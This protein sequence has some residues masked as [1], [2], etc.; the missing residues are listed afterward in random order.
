MREKNPHQVQYSTDSGKQSNHA[1]L[2]L[3]HDGGG[4]I[5]SYFLLG[6]L[7]RDVWAIHNPKYFTAEPWEGGIDEMASHYIELMKDAGIKGKILLGGTTVRWSL[8]GLLSLAIAHKLAAAAAKDPSSCD[9]TVTG[10]V[11]VDA[12]YHIPWSKL[13]GPNPDPELGPVPEL[14]RK[15]FSNCSGLLDN[16]ELPTW[17]DPSLGGEAIHRDHCAAGDTDQVLYKS[18]REDWRVLDCGRHHDKVTASPPPA[19]LLRCTHPVPTKET[20]PCRVDLF[21]DEPLLGW[22]GRYPDFIKA[23]VETD[24]HHFNVFEFSKVVQ[25]TA[26]LNEGLAVLERLS[27]LHR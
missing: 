18:L 7:H 8:G 17:D 2:I 5:F 14:I 1:P 20:D 19:L 9:L 15:S 25:A 24:A 13:Q 27:S 23:V 4:T 22:D 10:L 3:I 16:W 6:D 12:A 26:R 11:L 21:R